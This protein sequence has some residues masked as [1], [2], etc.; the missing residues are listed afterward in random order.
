MQTAKVKAEA[1]GRKAKV[2]SITEVRGSRFPSLVLSIVNAD[3]LQLAHS[4]QE[5][6]E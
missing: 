4:Y 2:C 6:L 5:L 3:S 1:L